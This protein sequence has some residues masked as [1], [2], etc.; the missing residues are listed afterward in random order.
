MREAEKVGTL[1]NSWPKST[2]KSL[3]NGMLF[4][5][6]L[7]ATQTLFSKRGKSKDGTMI[8]LNRLH[9]NL[10]VILSVCQYL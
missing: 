1:A 2:V 10:L 6:K 3:L 4:V 8:G 5:S 7:P 9:V